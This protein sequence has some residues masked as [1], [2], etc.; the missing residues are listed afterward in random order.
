MQ[1]YLVITDGNSEV[2]IPINA[3]VETQAPASASATP[4]VNRQTKYPDSIKTSAVALV[5]GGARLMD[6]CQAFGLPDSTLDNWLRK[7]R[8]LRPRALRPCFG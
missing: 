1:T 8:V 5:A 3:K 6:V 4:M 2:R 7:S